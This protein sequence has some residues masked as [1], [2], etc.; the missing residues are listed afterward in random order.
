MIYKYAKHLLH[1]E[2]IFI[3]QI[4]KKFLNFRFI[5]FSESHCKNPIALHNDIIK[6]PNGTQEDIY[7]ILRACCG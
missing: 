3:H 2:N 7:T 1:I 4:G 6:A 5:L